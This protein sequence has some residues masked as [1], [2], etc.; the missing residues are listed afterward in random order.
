MNALTVCVNFHDYLA[1]TLPRNARFFDEYVVAT[2]HEDTSTHELL[3]G[4]SALYTPA[5]HDAECAFNK[6]RAIAE[7]LSF[8]GDLCGDAWWCILDADIVLHP[9]FADAIENL[10]PGNIYMPRCRRQCNDPLTMV[11]YADQPPLWDNLPEMPEMRME[12]HGRDGG[13]G[14]CQIFHTSDPVFATHPWYPTDWP[15]AGGCDTEFLEW[16]PPRKRVRLDCEVL[17]LGKEYTHWCGRV[18]TF[19][20]GSKVP[21]SDKHA[22]AMQRRSGARGLGP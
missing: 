15:D 2:T 6:G 21:D 5:F 12:T 22:E 14:Y 10:E 3:V 9:N 13:A 17:H 4:V 19:L 20:D 11:E 1:I 18:G 7:A 8:A 16:W